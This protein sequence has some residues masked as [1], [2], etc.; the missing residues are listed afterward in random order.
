[1]KSLRTYIKPE[2][3]LVI[4]RC[5]LL[6]LDMPVHETFVDDEAVN[7]GNFYE[8]DEEDEYD[9]FLDEF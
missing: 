9:P 4:P 8:D 2:T 5:N 3:E 6:E 1:M 7:K